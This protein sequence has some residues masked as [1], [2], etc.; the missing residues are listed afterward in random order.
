MLLQSINVGVVRGV[1]ASR[2]HSV[3]LCVLV[4]RCSYFQ[5]L[6]CVYL[7]N[8]INFQNCTKF[9]VYVGGKRIQR[10][11]KVSHVVV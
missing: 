7:W 11:E 10:K 5:G 8:I 2:A 1:A 4:V 9:T 3:M 6:S